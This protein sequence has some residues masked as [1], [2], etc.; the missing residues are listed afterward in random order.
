V[1]AGDSITVVP[2]EEPAIRISELLG[3]PPEELLRRIVADG[4]VPDGWRKG[5]ARALERAGRR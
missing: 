5:A 1:A 4:R 3:D 2:A